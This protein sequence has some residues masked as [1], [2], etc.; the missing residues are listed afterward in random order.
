MIVLF[1]KTY[2]KELYTNGQCSDKR[3]RYQPQIIAKY[4]RIIALMQAE[5]NVN[6]LAKYVSLHYEHLQG[7]KK[8]WSS[9]RINDQYRIEFSEEMMGEEKIATIV[10]IQ[11]LSNHYK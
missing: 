11:E 6:C 10:D 3:H 2:L 4:K 5:Q 8:G 7:D 9:V 1:A